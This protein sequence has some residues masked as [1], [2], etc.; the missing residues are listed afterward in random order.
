MH[1]SFICKNIVG[2]YLKSF[3]SCCF[4]IEVE[5]RL[6]LTSCI[7]LADVSM[8]KETKKSLKDIFLLFFHPRMYVVFKNILSFEKLK[9]LVTFFPATTIYCS[10]KPY[11]LRL[12]KL[13]IAKVFFGK[14]PWK[15][16]VKG[17]SFSLC[18]SLTLFQNSNHCFILFHFLLYFYVV[19]MKH[20][21]LYNSFYLL[22]FSLFWRLSKLKEKR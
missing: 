19:V 3:H 13:L 22:V 4:T 18:N 8:R 10:K 6:A 20:L 1:F 2:S 17:S 12:S 11:T 15:Q 7:K 21:F 5:K 14:R 16:N 9:I